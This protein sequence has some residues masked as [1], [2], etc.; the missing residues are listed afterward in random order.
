MIFTYLR[1]RYVGNDRHCGK[2][3]KFYQ[4]VFFVYTSMSWAAWYK[5]SIGISQKIK[6]DH[7]EL[8]RLSC[9]LF[10]HFA[11]YFGKRQ[12]LKEQK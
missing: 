4:D 2:C 5:I 11:S 1:R 10:S 7:T 12:R 6:S 3:Q 8:L 9:E